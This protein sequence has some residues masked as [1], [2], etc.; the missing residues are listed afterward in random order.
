MEFYTLLAWLRSDPSKKDQFLRRELLLSGGEWSKK[1]EKTAHKILSRHLKELESHKLD[2]LLNSPRPT[3]EWRLTVD[4]INIHWNP[5]FELCVKWLFSRGWNPNK[6]TTLR[7]SAPPVEWI[8]AVTKTLIALYSGNMEQAIELVEE[9]KTYTSDPVLLKISQL[10]RLRIAIRYLPDDESIDD[11]EETVDYWG[12][13]PIGQHLRAQACALSAFASIE[14]HISDRLE[15]LTQLTKELQISSDMGTLGTLSHTMAI[16]CRRLGNIDDAETYLNQA[17]PIILASR[18]ILAIQNALF[19]LGH[20]R[21]VKLKKIGQKPDQAIFQL[22]NLNMEIRQTFGI[23]KD[24]AQCEILGATLALINGD[25]DLANSY[26]QEAEKFVFSDY[27]HACFHR[28]RARV[29]W[30]EAFINDGKIKENVREKVIQDLKV[31]LEMF[32][33]SGRSIPMVR[34]ELEIIES[35]GFPKSWRTLRLAS[36]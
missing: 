24:S 26:L 14:E 7:V 1:K 23:G 16:L 17:I 10:T 5:S 3:L 18:D 9:S 27:D 34:K 21:Y 11:V 8:V 28:A 36:P 32:G 33:R 6:A 22:L 31:S 25:I 2:S 20:C 19:T 30:N 13:S 12:D 29:I 4:P 35:G 15:S